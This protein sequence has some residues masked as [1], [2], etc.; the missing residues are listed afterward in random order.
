MATPDLTPFPPLYTS[1]AALL[2]ALL[3]PLQLALRDQREVL[4]R[5]PLLNREGQEPFQPE[6]DPAATVA[7]QSDI[8]AGAEPPQ[9]FTG[10]AWQGQ[11]PP[12]QSPAASP[13]PDGPPEPE[14][15][16]GAE[17]PGR[18][19]LLPTRVRLNPGPAPIPAAAPVASAEP[20]ASAAP[21]SGD[22]WRLRPA[23]AS[24]GSRGETV[25]TP[26]PSPPA[27]ALPS[28]PARD[29]LSVQAAVTLRRDPPPTAGVRAPVPPSA[30]LVATTSL[31]EE[32]A[33]T[34]ASLQPGFTDRGRPAPGAAS[35]A[36]R[37]PA[38]AS[39]WPEGK[40]LAPRASEPRALD[41]RGEGPVEAT[42]RQERIEQGEGTGWWHLP[43]LPEPIRVPQRSATS[44]P[45]GAWGDGFGV[46]GPWRNGAGP[47]LG[48]DSAR[49]A[50]PAQQGWSTP[51][52]P[53]SAQSG[54]QI[55]AAAPVR[56]APGPVAGGTAP[57]RPDSL[58]PLQLEAA[59]MRLLLAA[60][61]RH[62]VELEP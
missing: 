9:N 30:D 12:K 24:A 11:R 3:R 54:A 37:A 25:A 13:A 57:Q 58:D 47:A 32:A 36:A 10:A 27:V 23:P 31:G 14:R 40:T 62:G 18:P 16:S 61:Q 39:R 15:P 1:T 4:S 19:R 26:T 2:T 50:A 59:L 20:Y 46:R 38:L 60:A 43:R 44:G 41:P 8:E 55:A 34:T 21:G 49:E 28:W 48:R 53:P 56:E 33:A 7:G 51:P 5:W 35:P 17:A 45:P 22:R 6:A 29:P 52:P 42:P